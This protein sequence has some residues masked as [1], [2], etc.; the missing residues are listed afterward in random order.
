MVVGALPERSEIPV[1]DTWD[2]ESL[3]INEE[4][5]RKDYK[6]VENSLSQ[7]AAFKGHLGDSPAK[8]LE[9][10]NLSEKIQKKCYRLYMYAGL[11][12]ATDATN[13]QFA[14]L[15][16]MAVGLIARARAAASFEEPELMKIGF[17]K[18]TAWVKENPDLFLYA[19]Y[20][21]RLQ[22]KAKHIRSAEVEELL[23]RVQ[24]PL[25]TANGTHSLLANAD[26]TFKPARS[27][28][29]KKVDV[30]HSKIREIL[31]N[32]DRTL[33]RSGFNAY[34]DAHLAY[35]QTMSNCLAAGIKRDVFFSQARKYSSSLE[36][37]LADSNLPVE[38]YYSAM[39]TYRKHVHVWHHYWDVRR[40]AL[41]LKK[42]YVYDTRAALIQEMPEIPYQEAADMIYK[43]L[44]VM[45]EDY[46]ETARTGMLKDRWVDHRPNKGKVFGAFSAGMK[47]EKPFILM[48]YGNSIFDV[49][50]LAHEMGHSMHSYLTW[51][52]QP[53]IY[54]DYSLFVA[55]VA[56][57]FHQ[58]LVR[59]YLLKTVDDRNFKI[60]VIEEAMQ[61]FHRYMFIMPSLS[62]FDLEI[63][64][65]A[66]R[67]EPLTFDV[68]T[69]ILADIFQEGYG[70]SVIVD[71]ER[72]GSVWMQFSTHLYS[73]F[74]TY[75]YTTGIAA[76]NALAVD[77]L[78]GDPVA[79]KRYLDFLKVGSS[80]YP[81]DALK[82]AGIDMTKPEPL[83]KAFGVLESM[84]ETLENL[85]C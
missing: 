48:S 58:A 85:V 13:M 33:R 82:I 77:I 22:Q 62:I 17:E 40:R 31:A 16:D 55:E 15:N 10:L 41:N 63:H 5:W 80:V 74:Y 81:L 24:D 76:A 52:N 37:S 38:V 28:D 50:T 29:G 83:E 14:A 12:R 6:E 75:Q 2:I 78:A 32:N 64:Q 42:M 57:N 19:H 43:A 20:F 4:E 3:Y 68:M 53:W 65:R 79:L 60:A 66:E 71:R 73:N 21:D 61:N 18:L 59:G 51:Q 8:L 45:G 69:G 46:A 47:G 26:L 34:A 70:P 25:E 7:A 56:S 39:D 35:K 72:V 54:S 30:S 27:S 44:K 67:G 36:A 49:S 9:W 1:E 23:S 11:N 84:V